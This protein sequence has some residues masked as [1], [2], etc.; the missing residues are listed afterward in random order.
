MKSVK[1]LLAEL[2]AALLWRRAHGT[3]IAGQPST[4]CTAGQDKAAGR[5]ST[6]GAKSRREQY[7]KERCDG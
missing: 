3:G 1:S 2:S 4:S 5:A 6:Q 7:V